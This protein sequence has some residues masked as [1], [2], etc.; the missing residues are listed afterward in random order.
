MHVLIVDWLADILLTCDKPISEEL[1]WFSCRFF[2]FGL[3]PLV[4]KISFCPVISLWFY[5]WMKDLLCWLSSWGFGFELCCS[6]F[7]SWSFVCV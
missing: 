1:L 2:F 4:R 6:D 3:L 5:A 7:L